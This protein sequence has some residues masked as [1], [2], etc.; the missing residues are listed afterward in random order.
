MCEKAKLLKY[1]SLTL[2]LIRIGFQLWE[3]LSRLGFGGD[4]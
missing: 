1:V 3:L 2:Q 4:D